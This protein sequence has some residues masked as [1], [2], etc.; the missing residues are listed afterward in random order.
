MKKWADEMNVDIEPRPEDEHFFRLCALE[1]GD[2]SYYPGD[3]PQFYELRLKFFDL[4]TLSRCKEQ[5]DEGT[6]Q[7]L[8]YI[9]WYTRELDRG[10]PK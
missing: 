2:P 7:L 5:Q 4:P 10:K 1:L 3:W 6:M 8:R 9:L